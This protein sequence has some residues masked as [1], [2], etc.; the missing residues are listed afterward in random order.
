MTQAPA[1]ERS[2][3]T[4]SPRGKVS[5]K[6][7]QA[8]AARS[9]RTVA[10]P[11]D[12]YETDAAYVLLA[13]MP[14]VNPEGL[15]VTAERGELVIRGRTQAPATLPDY[16]EFELGTYQRMFVLT[17]DLDADRITATLR[18]GVLRLEIPKSP[19]VQPKKI[20]VRADS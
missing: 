9:T 7:S 19:K 15:D 3:R 2:D 18:E 5:Q 11:V 1:L 16:Q 8:L 13:D 20:P 12:I 10:P 6:G 17:E 14:G 4:E